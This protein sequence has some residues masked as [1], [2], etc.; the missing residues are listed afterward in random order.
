MRPTGGG[1]GGKFEAVGKGGEGRERG[2]GQ[3]CPE[4]EKLNIVLKQYIVLCVV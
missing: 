2:R 4:L 1:G 3:H